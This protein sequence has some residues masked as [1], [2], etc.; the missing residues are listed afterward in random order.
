MYRKVQLGITDISVARRCVDISPFQHKQIYHLIMLFCAAICRGVNPPSS[1]PFTLAPRSTRLLKFSI[2]PSIYATQRVPFYSL[3]DR[4][5]YSM[6]S[7]S[8]STRPL[9]LVSH[10][11]SG[12]PA[13]NLQISSVT[14]LLLILASP[15]QRQFSPYCNKYQK[16]RSCPPLHQLQL[17]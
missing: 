13:A 16:S 17:L 1:F 4:T 10:P 7:T 12:N 14:N 5:S 2:S 9:I 11:I 6:Y 3:I 8:T 15:L